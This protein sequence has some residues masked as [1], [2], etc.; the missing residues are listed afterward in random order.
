MKILWISNIVFPQL[1]R[2]LGI[3]VPFVGGWMEA[4]AKNVL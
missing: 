2:E 3:P 1:C 4:A